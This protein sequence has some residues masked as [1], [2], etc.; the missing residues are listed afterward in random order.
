MTTKPQPA[1]HVSAPSTWRY[2]EGRLTVR[3]LGETISLGRYATWEHA[4]KAAAAYFRKHG[5]R[6]Q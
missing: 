3:H 2:E 4:E 5:G 6:Q 1:S